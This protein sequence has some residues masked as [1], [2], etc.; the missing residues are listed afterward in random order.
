L[1]ESQLEIDIRQI[2]RKKRDTTFFIW[3]KQNWGKIPS[4][5][6]SVHLLFKKKKKENL[7]PKCLALWETNPQYNGEF[8]KKR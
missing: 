3:G 6:S 2:K 4:R 1:S 7:T 5:K 8:H